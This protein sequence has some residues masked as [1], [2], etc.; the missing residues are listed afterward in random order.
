MSQI[1]DPKSRPRRLP[2]AIQCARRLFS[3]DVLSFVQGRFRRGRAASRTRKG[4]DRTKGTGTLSPIT[5][6]PSKQTSM[7]LSMSD[8][9]YTDPRLDLE[10]PVDPNTRR[11]LVSEQTSSG[12][13]WGWAAAIAVIIVIMALVVGY[14]RSETVANNNGNQPSTAPSTTGAAPPPPRP[15][16]P[17]TA[18]APSSTPQA[19]PAPTPPSDS[20][21]P[22]NTPPAQPNTPP[23]QK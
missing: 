18:P 3:R 9:R 2:A 11:R 13:M 14:N 7:E 17:S 20:T 15:M 12:T 1:E 22:A 19:S 21:P 10:R 6:S 4:G 23:D 8:P 5:G 16:A